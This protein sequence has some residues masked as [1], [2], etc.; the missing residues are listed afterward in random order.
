MYNPLTR[1]NAVAKEANQAS[2]DDFFPV[3]IVNE[4]LPALKEMKREGLIRN[5]GFSGL[6]LAIYKKIL[7]RSIIDIWLCPPV[8]TLQIYNIQKQKQRQWCNW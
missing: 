2:C 1:F 7:D 5:I 3:Q 4:T 6:P 8:S